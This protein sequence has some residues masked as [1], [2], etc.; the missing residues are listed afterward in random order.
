MRIYCDNKDPSDSNSQYEN[1]GLKPV[2]IPQKDCI[3]NNKIIDF[4]TISGADMRDKIY[5]SCPLMITLYNLNHL[6]QC[7]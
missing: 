4:L 3:T 6:L 5:F 1:C 7:Q 2:I